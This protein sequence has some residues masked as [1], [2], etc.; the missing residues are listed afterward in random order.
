MPPSAITSHR[1]AFSTCAST[2]SE[3]RHALASKTCTRWPS[4]IAMAASS[5]IPYGTWRG[6][7]SSRMT[8]LMKRTLAMDELLERHGLDLGATD[9]AALSAVDGFAVGLARHLEEHVAE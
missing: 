9:N 3:A 2:A 1:S 8:G 7:S 6:S 4:R 5:A